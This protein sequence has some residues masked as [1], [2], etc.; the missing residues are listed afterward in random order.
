M[1]SMQKMTMVLGLAGLGASAFATNYTWDSSNLM[2]NYLSPTSWGLEESAT[3]SPASTDNLYFNASG[4]VVYQPTFEANAGQVDIYGQWKIQNG[5]TL[6][7]VIPDGTSLMLSGD[8]VGKDWDISRSTLDFAQGEIKIGTPPSDK[9]PY[10]RAYL[11]TGSRFYVH[12]EGTALL[13]ISDTSVKT[14]QP[15]FNA[16][17]G[18]QDNVWVRVYDGAVISNFWFRF[19]DYGR[20]CL[21]EL[22]GEKTVARAIN[23]TGGYNFAS[24]F[25]YFTNGVTIADSTMPF[26]GTNNTVVVEDAFVT[27]TAISVAGEMTV[28]RSR[29]VGTAPTFCS[30][31]TNSTIVIK[32]GSQIESRVGRC[33]L[34]SKGDSEYRIEG[35][36]VR[37]DILTTSLH[38]GILTVGESAYAPPFKNFQTRLTVTDGA[39]LNLGAVDGV[40]MSGDSNMGLCIGATAGYTP[41][42]DNEVL[43]LNGAVVT[44]KSTTN[45]GGGYQAYAGSNNRLVVSN[46]TYYGAMGVTIGDGNAKKDSSGNIECPVTNNVLEVLDGATMIVDGGMNLNVGDTNV[47]GGATCRVRNATLKIG[48][49]I[50]ARGA[51]M[52]YG[53]ARLEVGG[54]N[55]YAQVKKI[56]VSDNSEFHTK[57]TIPAKGKV[58]ELPYL[59]VTYTATMSIP[60]KGMDLDLAIDNEWARSGRKNYLDLMRISRGGSGPDFANQSDRLT[61][62]MNTVP[63]ESLNGCTLSIVTNEVDTAYDTAYGGRNGTFVLRL[64]A[65]PKRGIM[66]IVR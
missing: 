23:F 38:N 34:G 64:N 13:G 45:I 37:V 24:S 14:V 49:A 58:D 8:N 51:D 40:T 56:S 63:S 19:G 59:D 39:H 25:A 10:G 11:S 30:Q 66:F 2:G 43:F 12:G 55:G 29:F 31:A 61:T 18:R 4:G 21:F 15:G 16:N 48:S 27:N 36:D 47:C 35:K 32:D 57:I 60:V 5:S 46:A 65:G 6:R 22:S 41:A 1:K 7:L 53:A 28:S 17:S 44:N 62:I 42:C 52:A 9:V 54:T 3:F 33:F 26:S 20:D 50:I